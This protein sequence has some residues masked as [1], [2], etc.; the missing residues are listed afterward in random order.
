VDLR[1]NKFYNRSSIVEMMK[2]KKE[3]ETSEPKH[4]GPEA[5]DKQ[6]KS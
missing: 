5:Q 1:E 6:T 4:N 3:T 2:G